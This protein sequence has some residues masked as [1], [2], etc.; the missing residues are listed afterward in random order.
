MADVQPKRWTVP[1]PRLGTAAPAQG[2][3]LAY[4]PS[5]AAA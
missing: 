2:S 1:H 5:I 4:G 3:A